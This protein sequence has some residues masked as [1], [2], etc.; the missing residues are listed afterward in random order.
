[1]ADCG[2]HFKSRGF[3]E[4]KKGVALIHSV[5]KRKVKIPHLKI[6]LV[7]EE[8]VIFT[9]STYCLNLYCRLKIPIRGM[10]VVVERISVYQNLWSYLISI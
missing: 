1:M 8:N 7:P 2:D 9:Q 6:S 4:E 5:V 3:G 10:K